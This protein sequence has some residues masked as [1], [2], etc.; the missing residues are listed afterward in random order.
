MTPTFRILALC[1]ATIVAAPAQEKVDLGALYHIKREALQ[2][3]AVMDHAFWLTDVHGPRLTGSAN[4]KKAAEWAVERLKAYGMAD[5]QIESWGPFGRSWENDRFSVHLLEPSY[6]PIYGFPLAWTPGTDGVVSGEP[7][8]AVLRSESDLEQWK[9]KLKG[10]IV[11]TEAPRT[12][13][14]YAQPL[15][16]RHSDEDLER[17]AMLP[18]GLPPTFGP[19][20]PGRQG[21]GSPDMRQILAFRKKLSAFWRDEGAAV[22]VQYG[23]RGDGGTISAA[24]AGSRDPKDPLN[25]TTIAINPEHYNRIVRLLEKDVKVRLEVEVKNRMGEAGQ[26]SLNVI[27]NL[28]GTGPNKD[29]IVMIGGHLD[30]WHGGTGA[31]DNAAGSAVMIEVVRVLNKLKLPMNRTLRIALWG[32]EEQGLLGSRA[33]VRKTFGD[34]ESMELQPEWEKLSAYYNIDNG[35]GKIRGIYLQGN[36]MAR[37]VF[38]AWLGPFRDLG[39]TTVSARNTGGTDHLSFDLMGLPG[40]QFIQ[41]PVEYST[42]THHS[43][44]DV[45]DRLQADDLKQMAAVVASLVYH[46]ANRPEKLPRKPKP[47]PRKSFS[48][49]ATAN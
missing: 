3:S 11:F 32:G 30:S 36:E 41:D 31:T 34:W 18:E 26:D 42:R 28:P 9:G 2:N 7:V 38:E 13:Q 29:E 25:P 8:H 40:F 6:Q 20:S 43:N 39:V 35:T 45:Y 16:R 5:A 33:Y 24:S 19:Q 27:A 14:P 44:M 1:A 4:L 21:A 49:P 48:R 12:L 15:Y 17:I 46:T 23:Y 22:L 47:E 10:R 37:P